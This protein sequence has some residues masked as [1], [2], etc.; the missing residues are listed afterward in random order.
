[1]I[2][3]A[4]GQYCRQEIVEHP[5]QLLVRAC[6]DCKL[7]RWAHVQDPIGHGHGEQQQPPG[8]GAIRDPQRRV[9]IC[10]G[11]VRDCL[12]DVADPREPS[13]KMDPPVHGEHDHLIR[14]VERRD[15]STHEPNDEALSING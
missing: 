10:P 4:G 14:C 5:P 15:L 12:N 1:M 2:G 8:M 13:E 3:A 11:N 7:R 9:R 6:E